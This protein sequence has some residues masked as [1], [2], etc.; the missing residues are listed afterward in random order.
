MA[1]D[2]RYK[3]LIQRLDVYIHNAFCRMRIIS[4][5][6]SDKTL[7]YAYEGIMNSA[8]AEQSE[9]EDIRKLHRLL[10]LY[11][12]KIKG[13]VDERNINDSMLQKA[14]QEVNKKYQKKAD[15]NTDI[16]ILDYLADVAA[17]CRSLIQ[18]E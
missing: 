7:K 10:T 8:T 9:N 1:A 14:V 2:Y 5:R 17:N 18:K 11:G 15:G 4:K 6:Q 12:L 13:Y 16:M 3:N